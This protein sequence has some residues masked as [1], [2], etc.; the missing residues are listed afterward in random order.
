MFI[1][2]K[3]YSFSHAGGTSEITSRF[4]KSAVINYSWV[5]LQNGFMTPYLLIDIIPIDRVSSDKKD[6]YF[7]P[8]PSLSSVKM[9]NWIQVILLWSY[10]ILFHHL[11]FL[12]LLLNFLILFRVCRA[13]SAAV[14]ITTTDLV[15]KSVA[16]ESEVCL[17]IINIFFIIPFMIDAELLWSWT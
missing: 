6:D 12:I 1:W 10:S 5:I 13:D 14:A 9:H 17:S 16:I 4:S 2:H 15:S 11:Y 7:M 3:F 8:F